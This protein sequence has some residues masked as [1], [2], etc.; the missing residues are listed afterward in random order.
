METQLVR[1]DA[2]YNLIC[3]SLGNFALHIAT[4]IVVEKQPNVNSAGVDLGERTVARSYPVVTSEGSLDGQ[5]W[6]NTELKDCMAVARQNQDVS[7]FTLKRVMDFCYQNAPKYRTDFLPSLLA[8]EALRNGIKFNLPTDQ[9]GRVVADYEVRLVFDDGGNDGACMVYSSRDSDFYFFGGFRT[10]VPS[11]EDECISSL[12]EMRNSYLMSLRRMGLRSIRF[13]TEDKAY[14][15][16][17]DKLNRYRV[18]E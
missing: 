15:N 16:F 4:L 3:D 17:V 18:D 7:P 12:A 2:P 6:M 8:V 5:V 13:T 11:D 9:R 10:A 14:Q 1:L